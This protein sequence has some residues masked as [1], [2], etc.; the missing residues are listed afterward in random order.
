[1]DVMSCKEPIVAVSTPLGYGAIG[2]I[3]MSGKYVLDIALKHFSIKGDVKPRFAYYGTFVDKKGNIIDEGILIYYKAPKSYTGEDMVELNLHGNPLILKKAVELF[4][5]AGARLA[6]PGEFTRRAFLNGKMD[7][8]QAEAVGDLISAKGELA[9]KNAINQ[10]RGELS[11]LIKPLREDLINLLSLIEA[12]I[13][14][15]EEDIPVIEREQILQITDK[16]IRDIEN[17]LSTY[18]R[19]N[20]IKEGIKLAIVGK[21][22]VGKSSIFNALIGKDRSIV[23]EIP[24]TTRDYVEECIDI[25]G[26]PIVLSDTAG[27]RKTND[28]VEKIGVERSWRNIEGA[29]IIIFVFDLS[30]GVTEEDISIYKKIN[31]KN[32]IIVGNKIDLMQKRPLEN[33]DGKSI[34]MVSA[35]TR[36][37]ILDLEK[38][39]VENVGVVDLGQRVCISL[40]HAK[41]LKDSLL[42]VEAFRKKTMEGVDMEIAILELKNA[43]NK[44]SEVIGYITTEDVLVGIFSKFCIGK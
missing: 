18:E 39:I 42:S 22:N 40:R 36:E 34:I 7:L 29:D 17:L 27:I 14:F 24:G 9:L 12:D 15:G 35:L 38:A 25:K 30:E 21:P 33:F 10:L 16:V 13:D 1:M 11:S 26:I 31:D 8:T 4:V 20:I 19:G 23:T 32:V 37:G 43:I 41:L 2:I 5:E 44:L 28:Q 6:E 3:R